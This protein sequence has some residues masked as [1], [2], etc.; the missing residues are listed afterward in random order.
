MTRDMNSSIILLVRKI[1]EA[2]QL[3]GEHIAVELV[4]ISCLTKIRMRRRDVYSAQLFE[5]SECVWNMLMLHCSY[6]IP[7]AIA[8]ILYGKLSKKNRGKNET[9]TFSSDTPP[10]PFTIILLF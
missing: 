9:G 7:I 2:V 4:T 5:T 10:P 6:D 1:S 3:D 8:T